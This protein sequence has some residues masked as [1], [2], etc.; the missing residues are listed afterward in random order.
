MGGSWTK[1]AAYL[2]CGD[3]MNYS[4]GNRYPDLGFRP[5]RQPLGRDW[6]RQPRKL[7]AVSLGE[8]KVQLS[9]ALL[10]TDAVSTRFHVYRSAERNDAGFRIS[11]RPIDD[12]WSMRRR[13]RSSGNP[14]AMMVRCGRTV[15]AAGR[16][17]SGTVRRAWNASRTAP[18]T[19]TTTSCSSHHEEVAIN[20]G[21]SK[22]VGTANYGSV[23]AMRN[24]SFEASHDLPESD[25]AA[26]HQ[27]VK[28]AFVACHPGR[29][30]AT[31]TRWYDRVQV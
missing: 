13:A 5:V 15:T 25:L 22:K 23:G 27:K 17:T 16:P 28:N 11:E 2:R 4:P 7:S 21:L 12:G 8:G 31:G 6:S 20:V 9:W 29:L 14:T 1:S 3:R 10:G 26:F 19:R 18:G 24:V 30:P